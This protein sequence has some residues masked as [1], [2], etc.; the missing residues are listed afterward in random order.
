MFYD[1]SPIMMVIKMF[2]HKFSMFFKF[3]LFSSFPMLKDIHPLF[4]WLI[5]NVFTL[6]Q[7]RTFVKSRKYTCFK[8][9][10]SLHGNGIYYHQDTWNLTYTDVINEKIELV[11]FSKRNNFNKKGNTGLR[12]VSV[13]MLVSHKFNPFIPNANFLCPLKTSRSLARKKKIIRFAW[14]G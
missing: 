7:Y 14:I 6:N 12:W 9:Y 8:R 11:M 10:I 2:R 5:L 4:L 13:R 1:A 3:N